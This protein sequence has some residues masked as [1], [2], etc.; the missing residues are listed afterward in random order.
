MAAGRAMPDAFTLSWFSGVLE[1][2]GG[3]LLTLGL[4]TRPIAFVLSGEMAFAYFIGHA[5]RGFFPVLNGGDA[6]ILFCFVFLYIAA[7]GSG[8]WRV[9]A[10][11]TWSVS[12]TSR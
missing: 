6:A 10:T 12:T 5:P 2:A 3:V 1:L 9:D 4:F 7:A 11:R 8:P